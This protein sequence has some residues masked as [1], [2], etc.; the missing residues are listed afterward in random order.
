V[1]ITAAPEKGYKQ[2]KAGLG[3][4]ATPADFT[5]FRSPFLIFAYAL[6]KER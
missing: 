6:N 5:S 2:K 4:D 3:G 1:M